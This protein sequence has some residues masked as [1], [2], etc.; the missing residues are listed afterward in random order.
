[1]A[2]LDAEFLLGEMA[3]LVRDEIKTRPLTPR[4]CIPCLFQRYR[5][6]A[7]AVHRTLDISIDEMLAYPTADK[8]KVTCKTA[9]ERDALSSELCSLLF[10][11]GIPAH[12]LLKSNLQTGNPTGDG[13]VLSLYR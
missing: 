8:A 12:K 1:M 7:T 4:D 11:R 3:K 6:M 13:V 9:E 5:Q 10:Q 2:D